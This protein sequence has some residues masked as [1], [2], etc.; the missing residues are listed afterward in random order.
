LPLSAAEAAGLAI[1]VFPA[2]VNDWLTA[3]NAGYRWRV[4]DA[5]AKRQSEAISAPVEASTLQTTAPGPSLTTDDVCEAF[6]KVGM[7]SLEWRTTITK[8]LPD[9]LTACR[10]MLG[11][12]G[13][14]PVQARWDPL[15]IAVALVAG[16]SRKA[17]AVPAAKLD[18]AFK[19][20]PLLKKFAQ[21]WE[22]LRADH[23]A[24]GD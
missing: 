21:A 4:A 5:S 10:T 8:N 2:D 23:P 6:D 14:N 18:A 16:V 15:K 3:C 11:K 22:D 12:P 9:W 17:G 20:Q 19:R 13:A 24:W 1:G 7:T